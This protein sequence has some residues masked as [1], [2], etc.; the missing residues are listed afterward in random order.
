MGADYI[1]R[2]DSD[3]LIEVDENGEKV[4]PIKYELNLLGKKNNDNVDII[5]CGGGYKGEY[6]IDIGSFV[7]DDDYS[8][9]KKC[10]P[11]Y[12]SQKNFMTK[13]L[14]KIFFRYVMIN[15]ML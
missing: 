3:I 2:R 12:L 13:L 14:K 5:I 4:F 7:D 6:S 8:K 15:L 11:V 9:V 10:L 1:T